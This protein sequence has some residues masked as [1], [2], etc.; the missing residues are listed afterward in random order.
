MM[1]VQGTLVRDFSSIMV[2]VKVN[3]GKLHLFRYICMI[4]REWK[5]QDTVLGMVQG[6]KMK[7]R[8]HRELL[9]DINI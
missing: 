4:Y 9:N 2:K 7:G 8:Q 5:I 6:T 3:T 1:F